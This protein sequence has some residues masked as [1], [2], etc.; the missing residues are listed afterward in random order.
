MAPNEI[1]EKVFRMLPRR[2]LMRAVL[3]CRRWRDVGESPI[4]WA[5]VAPHCR[6]RLITLDPIGLSLFD[7]DSDSDENYKEEVEELWENLFF[8]SQMLGLDKFRGVEEICLSAVSGELLEAILKHKGLKR[9]II[10]SD[11]KVELELILGTW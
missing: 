10:A 1:L 8:T 9:V 7:S 5:W 2:D 3:V 4:L 6:K 11:F